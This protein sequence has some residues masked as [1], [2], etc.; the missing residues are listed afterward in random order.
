MSHNY[1]YCINCSVG[2]FTLSWKFRIMKRAKHTL[3]ICDE[4]KKTAANS[5]SSLFEMN[6]VSGCYLDDSSLK[7][8]S[9]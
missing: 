1:A 2:K 4:K 6:N 9:S 8:F 3:A 5:S 7:V